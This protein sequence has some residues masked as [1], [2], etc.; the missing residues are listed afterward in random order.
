[1]KRKEEE[2]EEK[3]HQHSLILSCAA[4]YAMLIQ[5]A[6]KGVQFISS[7]DLEAQAAVIYIRHDV[8]TLH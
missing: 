3:E 8:Y 5:P 7:S 1:M 4:S 2:E 6:M